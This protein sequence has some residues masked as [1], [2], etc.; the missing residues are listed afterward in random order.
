MECDDDVDLSGKGRKFYC[1]LQDC[2]MDSFDICV[3]E[4]EASCAKVK[5][6]EIC[7]DSM[8]KLPERHGSHCPSFALPVTLILDILEL[9]FGNTLLSVSFLCVF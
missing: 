1:F 2:V 7:L 3:M 4:G 8:S 5:E 9:Y 6:G